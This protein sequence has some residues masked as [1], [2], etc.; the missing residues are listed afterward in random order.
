MREVGASEESK[1]DS[2][3]GVL[4]EEDSSPRR[5]WRGGRTHRTFHQKMREFGLH[6]KESGTPSGG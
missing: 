3:T 6:P 5:G 2:K 1:K 4:G